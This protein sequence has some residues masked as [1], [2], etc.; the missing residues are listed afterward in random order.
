M[1]LQNYCSFLKHDHGFKIVQKK[2]L[3]ESGVTI[4]ATNF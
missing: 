2:F 4:S 1:V 3:D